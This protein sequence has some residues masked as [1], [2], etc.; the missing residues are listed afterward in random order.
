MKN[1]KLPF[2]LVAALV[3]GLANIS[4]AQYDDLY[5][6]P[7]KDAGYY[8]SSSNNSSNDSYAS[9]D[10]NDSDYDDEVYEDYEDYDDYD[11]YYTSRI[12]RFHRPYY[13]FSYFDPVYVDLAYYDPFWSPGA[14][15]LIYDSYNPWRYNRWN[16]FNYGFGWSSWGGTSFYFSN[17]G[18][19]GNPWGSP[20]GWNNGYY[21]GYGYGNN[22]IVNNY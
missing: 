5:Y 17:G 1:N 2:A 3:L 15:V 16:R 19:Y 7:D 20:W 22:Y 9:N 14:T 13:G 10:R 8:Y 4:L 11:Y 21:G 18:Y 6:D 12:R